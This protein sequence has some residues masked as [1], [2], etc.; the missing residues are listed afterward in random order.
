MDNF[1]TVG[2]LMTT[3]VISIGPKESMD[4]VQQIF[5]EHIIHHI[6]VVKDNKVIGMISKSDYYQL[7]HGFTLF[8]SAKS[9]AY[10]KAILR[11][12]LADEVMIKQLAT[13]TPDASV[14]TAADYFRENLF[15]AIPIVDDTGFLKGIITTYDLINHFFARPLQEV[16]T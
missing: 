11:S 6:P 12:L 7:L 14:Y 4:K 1:L 13:L 10:N 5:E 15:H 16:S 3:N 8:K 9:E 2:A